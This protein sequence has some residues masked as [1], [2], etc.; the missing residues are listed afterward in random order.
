MARATTVLKIV[1]GLPRRF[2]KITG[3]TIV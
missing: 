2:N 1:G 3:E